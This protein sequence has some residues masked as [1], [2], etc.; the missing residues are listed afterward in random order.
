MAIL[1]GQT[2]RAKTYVTTCLLERAWKRVVL[3]GVVVRELV[4]HDRQLLGGGRAA[5]HCVAT[6]P[7]PGDRT[8]RNR[9][10]NEPPELLGVMIA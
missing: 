2:L 9:V 8:T 1:P 10:P 5:S 3:G 4:A 7:Q 6:S